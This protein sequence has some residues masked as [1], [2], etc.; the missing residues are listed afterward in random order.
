MAN[1]M[2][3]FLKKPDADSM[4]NAKPLKAPK[5]HPETQTVE[6]TLGIST[7]AA[8][9]PGS[10]AASTQQT[11]SSA[12]SSA[13]A[14]PGAAG[15]GTLERGVEALKKSKAAQATSVEAASKP[16]ADQPTSVLGEGLR[17]EGELQASESLIVLGE[18]SGV[19]QHEG[20]LLTVGETGK[21]DAEIHAE[22][23]LVDGIITGDIYCSKSVT[24]N[25]TANVAGNIKTVRLSIADG[26]HFSG[27]ID[28]G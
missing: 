21:V 20:E 28:M 12:G 1:M 5:S 24:I 13:E 15:D 10:F 25:K 19:I 4:G 8:P 11:D 18:I 17:I 27:K 7:A 2:T 26:A 22:S 14:K 6:P 3:K 9:S 23:L 16:T